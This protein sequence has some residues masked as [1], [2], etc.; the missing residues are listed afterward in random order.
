MRSRN[1]RLLFYVFVRRCETSLA[2]FFARWIEQVN[3]I[4]HYCRQCN[5]EQSGGN[6]QSSTHKH[7]TKG[8]QNAIKDDM[9]KYYCDEAVS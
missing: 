8:H 2:T 1:Q 3:D 7:E 4:R 6:V 9:G 5:I